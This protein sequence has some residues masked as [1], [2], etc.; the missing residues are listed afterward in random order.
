MMILMKLKPALVVAAAAVALASCS[1][2]PQSAAQVCVD[3]VSNMRVDDS[4]CQP[5]SPMHSMMWWYVTPGYTIPAYGWPVAYGYA[6]PPHGYIA[7]TAPSSGGVINKRSSSQRT[8]TVRPTAAATQAPP[9]RKQSTWNKPAAQKP[10][11]QSRPQA[12]QRPQSKPQWQTYK[13]PPASR[14][15]APRPPSYPK[16]R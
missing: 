1:G 5:N 15:V 6:H 7:S 4:L 12:Q 14:P 16:Y 11:T 2:D 10:A 9:P 8:Q 3:P 13:P